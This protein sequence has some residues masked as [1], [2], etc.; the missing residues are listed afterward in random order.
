MKTILKRIIFLS[1]V[2]LILI[3][4]CDC[5]QG[6]PV[7]TITEAQADSMQQLYIDNHHK[8]I[9]IGIEE[10]YQN[11]EPDNLGA[12][13]EDIDDQLR[14]L[15]AVK[16]EAARQNKSNP[17]IK[18]SYGAKIDENGVPR[19]APYFMA[20]YRI[21]SVNSVGNII[22]Y[23]KRLNFQYAFSDKLDPMDEDPEKDDN[24]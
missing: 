14:Y 20:I 7:N 18:L 13:I 21:D 24:P 3:S 6:N 9:N 23:Y 5:P 4:C 16:K 15:I 12:I 19:S 22:P 2:G 11:G 1:A 17:A 8:F 10:E